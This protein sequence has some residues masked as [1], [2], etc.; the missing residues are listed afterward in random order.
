MPEQFEDASVGKVRAKQG[1]DEV[2]HYARVCSDDPLFVAVEGGCL[3]S[4]FVL[5]DCRSLQQAAH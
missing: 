3:G 4:T 2:P 1:E 5:D